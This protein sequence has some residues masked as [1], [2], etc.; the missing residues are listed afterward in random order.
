MCYFYRVR[1]MIS[2]ETLAA[3]RIP[4]DSSGASVASLLYALLTRLRAHGL[5]TLRQCFGQKTAGVFC[6]WII[7]RI[8]KK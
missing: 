5:S 7:D 8:G 1:R 6:W 2:Q 4:R 3:E